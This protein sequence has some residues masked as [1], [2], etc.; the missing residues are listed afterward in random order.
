MPAEASP[1]QRAVFLK[2]D[3]DNNQIS[4]EVVLDGT[5]LV[6]MIRYEIVTLSSPEKA[7]NKTAS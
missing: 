3:R 1:R 2:I 6:I 4:Q 5:L 7:L